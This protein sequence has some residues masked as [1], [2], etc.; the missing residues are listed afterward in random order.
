MRSA[1]VT[2]WLVLLTVLLPCKQ[3]RAVLM[4][5]SPDTTVAA[6]GD[7]IH[8]SV[9]MTASDTIRSFNVYLTY[10][11]NDL[12][13]A[14][15]PQAGSL[16]QGLPGLDFRYNDHI[17]AAPDWLEVGAVIFGSSSWVGPG[18]L[19]TMGLVMRECGV[20]PMTGSFGMRRIDGAY[21]PG[22]FLPPALYICDAPPLAPDSLTITWD[23]TGASLRWMPVELNTYGLPIPAPSYIILRSEEMPNEFP[24]TPIDT[25]VATIYVDSTA[26]GILHR[27]VVKAFL[28]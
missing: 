9:L 2:I 26:P 17:L 8:F 22:D 5:F 11:T 16:I 20:L 25:T 27:Y 28:P 7:T 24:L 12:D 21:I 15:A 18:E 1:I 6:A 3:A 4:Y 10:D 19:F 23:G 13:L 14:I